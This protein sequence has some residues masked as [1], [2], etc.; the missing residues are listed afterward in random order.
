MESF[1]TKNFK[2]IVDKSDNIKNYLNNIDLL[3]TQSAIEHF[4]QDLFF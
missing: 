1:D 4:D 2:F 3:F